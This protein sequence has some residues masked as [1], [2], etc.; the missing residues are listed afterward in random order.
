MRYKLITGD[1]AVEFSQQVA[2]YLQSGYKLH[3]ETQVIQSK[4]TFSVHYH[5]FQAVVME[6]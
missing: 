1:N 5:F 4:D 2:G 3:G 6:D